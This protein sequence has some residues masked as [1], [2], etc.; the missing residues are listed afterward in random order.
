[1]LAADLAAA[2][3]YS[4]RVAFRNEPA[5]AALMLEA[6]VGTAYSKPAATF[7]A[8]SQTSAAAAADGCAVLLD[9]ISK[10][11]AL[12]VLE[13]PEDV[14][15]PRPAL[16]MD[17]EEA[18]NLSMLA[19]AQQSVQPAGSGARSVAAVAAAADAAAKAAAELAQQERLP[20]LLR[21]V[22]LLGSC[23][24]VMARDQQQRHALSWGQVASR[25]GRI[26]ELCRELAGFEGALRK[27]TEEAADEIVAALDAWCE[28]EGS[29]LLSD[30]TMDFVAH[31]LVRHPYARQLMRKN[32]GG[33]HAVLQQCYENPNLPADQA[34]AGAGGAAG[35]AARAAAAA[36]A[37]MVAA[38]PAAAREHVL[39]A[40]LLS[41]APSEGCV[42]DDAAPCGEVEG[43]T[44]ISD[45]TQA[46][47]A[48][49][50]VAAQA[51][52]SSSSSVVLKPLDVKLACM[53][54]AVRAMRLYGT[55]LGAALRHPCLDASASAEERS[56]GAAQLAQQLDRLS[57]SGEQA[58]PGMVQ[59][60][61]HMFASKQCMEGAVGAAVAI[62]ALLGDVPSDLRH[63]EMCVRWVGRQ[64]L[65]GQ[66]P[67]PIRGA[68]TTVDADQ[69]EP[70]HAPAQVFTDTT[71]LQ[72]DAELLELLVTDKQQSWQR[73]QAMH[74]QMRPQQSSNGA[75]DAQQLTAD[76]TAGIAAAWVQ[77]AASHSEQRNS[78]RE[79]VQLLA[80]GIAEE[81]CGRLDHG[82][83]GSVDLGLK[84]C[85]WADAVAAALPS[86]RCCSNPC[87]VSGRWCGA[88]AA[89]VA[90]AQLA[91]ARR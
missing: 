49:G 74:I 80:S 12:V 7:T 90:A 13:D 15:D 3:A 4:L 65:I 44:G 75:G 34:A 20:L 54:V 2:D 21:V 48:A 9:A 72:H 17:L 68:G 82:D 53:A 1:L 86:R 89:C 42:V 77:A 71:V 16:L 61:M 87:C 32:L 91:A 28:K 41:G 40:V 88:A 45:Q 5:A 25:C 59:Q 60:Q 18:D 50:A 73:L 14:D 69:G 83:Q 8:A 10:L 76:D 66:Q 29:S 79:L 26:A 36:A 33:L 43:V 31:M 55:V 64:L 39:L 35:D 38:E 56:A 46:A 63:V 62:G 24:K 78:T 51:C 67:R 58:L 84:L 27:F 30:A 19:A 81:R 47:S 37:A 85:T 6:A 23:V 11:C 22:S 57:N 70:A 52:G